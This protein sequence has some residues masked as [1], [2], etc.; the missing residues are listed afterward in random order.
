MRAVPEPADIH[1]GACSD[2]LHR[3]ESLDLTLV[4]V[5]FPLRHRSIESHLSMWE[6]LHPAPR[7]YHGR[8]TDVPYQ[9]FSKFLC[10]IEIFF[11]EEV[12]AFDC[13]LT[14]GRCIF[15][16]SLVQ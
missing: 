11:C 4:V 12:E 5:V 10:E 6:I 1:S 3:G 9:K 16:I 2:V 8:I 15:D 7:R 13:L 14:Q